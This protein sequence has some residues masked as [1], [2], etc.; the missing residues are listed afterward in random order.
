MVYISVYKY[1][2]NSDP[3]SQNRFEFLTQDLFVFLFTQEIF[4]FKKS[5]I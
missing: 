5:V 1:Y 4:F 3:Q 2:T